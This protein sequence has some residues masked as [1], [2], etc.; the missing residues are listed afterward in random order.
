MDRGGLPTRPPSEGRRTGRRNR[1]TF[2]GFT[3]SGPMKRVYLAWKVVWSPVLIAMVLCGQ[4]ALL[5]MVGLLASTPAASG[6]TLFYPDGSGLSIV[7]FSPAPFLGERSLQLD[8]PYCPGVL[9]LSG[10]PWPPRCPGA[11]VTIAGCRDLGC[12]VLDSFRA[13]VTWFSGWTQ[14]AISDR[15][16]TFLLTLTPLISMTG[17][18]YLNLTMNWSTGWGFPE[19]VS[20]SGLLFAGTT[21][22]S[23]ALLVALWARGKRSGLRHV[24]EYALAEYR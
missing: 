21:L 13:S 15:S 12:Q 19:G 14:I 8:N 5:S 1:F 11:T 7:R 20:E 18:W 24:L 9:L 3:R 6:A 17:A 2:R 22:C 23:S 4:I 16:T 10:N